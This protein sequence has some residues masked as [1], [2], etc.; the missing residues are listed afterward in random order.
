MQAQDR[1]HRIGQKNEVRVLRLMTVNS[2]EERIN[3]AAKYKLNLDE[4]IIQAGMFDQKSTLNERQQFLQAVMTSETEGK[5]IER[6][7]IQK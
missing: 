7:K 3:A 1:A 6:K 4:K 2:V 5:V